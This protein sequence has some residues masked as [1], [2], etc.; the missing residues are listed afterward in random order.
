MTSEE[1]KKI[2]KY[3][4]KI[5]D[6]IAISKMTESDGFSKVMAA[7]EKERDLFKYQDIFGLNKDNLI[8]LGLEWLFGLFKKAESESMKPI[9]NEKT[10]KLE[11]LRKVAKKK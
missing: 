5:I 2:K 7:L 3:N 1:N 4:K 11:P 8:V 9:C 6:A 10:G